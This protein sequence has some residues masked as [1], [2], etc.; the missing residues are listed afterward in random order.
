MYRLAL[1]ALVALLVLAVVVWLAALHPMPADGQRSG[2]YGESP[3]PIFHPARCGRA[4]AGQAGPLGD[5]SGCAGVTDG[6][7]TAVDF[8]GPRPPCCLRGDCPPGLPGQGGPGGQWPGMDGHAGHAGSCS[9]GREGAQGC[10][11]GA[12]WSPQYGM[13]SSPPPVWAEPGWW[14]T[15]IN[16]P[17]PQL[18]P[19]G[20]DLPAYALNFSLGF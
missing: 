5:G 12:A 19:C 2:F 17:L 11:T 4:Y 18:M 7:P 3:F 6:V 20:L 10:D 16:H 13:Q 1:A 14:P 9:K 15:A 8:T